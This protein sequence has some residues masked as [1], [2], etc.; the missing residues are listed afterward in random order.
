M[1][2]ARNHSAETPEPQ[3]D[4]NTADSMEEDTDFAGEHSR[5]TFAEEDSPE[6]APDE[7]VPDGEGGMDLKE[8]HRPE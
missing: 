4:Q 6:G 5:P 2:P 1:T 3:I 7:L 8:R